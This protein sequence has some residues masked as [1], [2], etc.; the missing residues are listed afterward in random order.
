MK[1]AP[2]KMDG[3]LFRYDFGDSTVEYITKATADEIKLESDWAEKHDGERLVGIGKDGYIILD[4]V[5]L[6]RENWA[7]K[8]VRDEYLRG[9]SDDLDAEMSQL[10]SDFV[11]FELPLLV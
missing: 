6:R 5:G 8:E 11:E 9:W 3:K 4:T 7:N 2:Y 10:A 1:S